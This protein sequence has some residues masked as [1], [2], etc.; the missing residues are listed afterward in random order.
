MALNSDHFYG[1]CFTFQATQR[2]STEETVTY[3][4]GHV[5]KETLPSTTVQSVFEGHHRSDLFCNSSK[6]YVQQRSLCNLTF[7]NESAKKISQ[8]PEGTVSTIDNEGEVSC[9]HFKQT[10]VHYMTD[11]SLVAVNR[12]DAMN[13]LFTP[14]KSPILSLPV[15]SPI[16][17]DIYGDFNQVIQQD[18]NY[19]PN[20]SDALDYEPLQVSKMLYINKEGLY[21]HGNPDSTAQMG[22]FPA[23]TSSCS[24]Q[25]Q[26]EG[27]SCQSGEVADWSLCTSPSGTYRY[28]YPTREYATE[29]E[30]T[31][32][33]M[34]NDAFDNLREVV[35]REI[36]SNNG[37]ITTPG[38]S[39][40]LS[41]I[42]T[43]RR[44]IRYMATLVR[45]LEEDGVKVKV[46]CDQSVYDRRG[47]RRGRI[48]RNC[49][50]YK[51]PQV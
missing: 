51:C 12:K 18:K 29:R 15:N 38:E 31:R 32:M 23:N 49:G 2:P 20:T 3:S 22:P 17:T 44:A 11:S 48:R 6:P 33:H 7:C 39:P 40:K 13:Q 21:Y 36:G 35:P 43:L 50:I 5:T 16:Q 37:S 42:A 47:R 34:L 26:Q 19:G 9:E 46:T 8:T 30:R 14:E 24:Y 28:Q 4:V 25:G 1:N 10:E 41:K 27:A 45:V